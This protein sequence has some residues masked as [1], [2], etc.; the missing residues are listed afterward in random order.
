MNNNSEKDIILFNLIKKNNQ[1]AFEDLFNKYY[2][3]LCDFSY[4]M[5]SNKSLAEEVVAD[6]F[7][8][9]WIKR[10][11]IHIDKNLQSYLFKSTKNLTI[12]YIRKNKK[13][14]VF[15]DEDTFFSQ[16]LF[17]NQEVKKTKKEMKV[18]AEN[19]LKIVPERSR[20][21]FILHRYNELK[22]KDIAEMLNISV[23]TVE[24]HMSKAL[25]LLR[26][27]YGN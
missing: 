19:L 4:M 10:K 26:E 24:K 13:P 16:S 6:V 23:K 17:V 15:F 7:A 18:E 11:K 21:V 1:K 27:N 3:T 22:Y 12:S 9:I 8:N 20:E 14:I 2:Q 5:T 25:K